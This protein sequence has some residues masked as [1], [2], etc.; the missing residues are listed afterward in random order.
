MDGMQPMQTE[1][2]LYS[3]LGCPCTRKPVALPADV[4]KQVAEL[5][6]DAAYSLK[7]REKD[8][9]LD[10]AEKSC[11]NQLEKIKAQKAASNKDKP[12][13]AS[14]TEGPMPTPMP[15]AIMPPKA[16]DL[17]PGAGRPCDDPRPQKPEDRDGRRAGGKAEGGCRGQSWFLHGD[18]IL[19]GEAEATEKAEENYNL[20]Y[21]LISE[22]EAFQ[23]FDNSEPHKPQENYLVKNPGNTLTKHLVNYVQEYFDDMEEEIFA[24]G[25]M[26]EDD[27]LDLLELCCEENSLL[28][29]VV[30]AAGGKA[31]RAGLFNGCDLMTASGREKV[32]KI[33]DEKKPRWIWVSYPCGP[34]SPIQHLNEISEEGWWQSMRRKQRARRL[35]KHG[36]EILI[37]YVKN[38]GNLVWEWPRYNEGW[39]LPEVRSFWAQI[40]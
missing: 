38:G 3:E 31:E 11:F 17:Q 33:I 6:E 22:N 36:N 10:G 7:L 25:G 4:E 32:Q 26:R 9:G 12:A 40:D 34:T 1:V 18:F 28:T 37:K 19:G 27:R 30:R 21:E 2:E 29:E 16:S 13:A 23:D 14:N 5:K 15:K 24:C 20:D 35:V 39:H 8:I